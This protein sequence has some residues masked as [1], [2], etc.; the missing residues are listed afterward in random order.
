M[1][2]HEHD[3]RRYLRRC[4]GLSVHTSWRDVRHVSLSR[5]R[6]GLADKR[7]FSSDQRHV[8]EMIKNIM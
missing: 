1:G 3:N 8:A 6:C 4:S 5:S 2:D 7:R